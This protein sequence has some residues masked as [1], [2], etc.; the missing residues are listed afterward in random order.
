M[1]AVLLSILIFLYSVVSLANADELSRR[2]AAEELLS[3]TKADQ[4]VKALSGQMQTM[5]EQQFV[6]ME[7]PTDLQPIL[8]KYQA[9]LFTALEQELDSQ[10][11]KKDVVSV[12]V[13]TFTEDELQGI[14]DFYKSPIGQ[15]WVEKTPLLISKVM[16]ISQKKIPQ[17]IEK[18]KGI[19]AKLIEEMKSEVQ[20]KQDERQRQQQREKL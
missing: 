8:K 6:Q 4:M 7:V 14:I 3:L 17:I 9:R 12:Y 20:K 19:A 11:W 16:Q 2:A 18:M 15:V 5:M 13:D 1:R 10:G